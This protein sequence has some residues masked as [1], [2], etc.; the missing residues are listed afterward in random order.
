MFRKI[1]RKIRGQRDVPGETF[2]SFES[3]L[4]AICKHFRPKEVLE[5][6]PG[7][8][9]A[10]ILEHSTAHIVA[11][12]E[13]KKWYRK[14][15]SRFPSERF[16]LSCKGPGWDLR[17]VNSLG[18]PYDLIFVDGGD[19][20]AQLKHCVDLLA[21]D[22]IVVLHDAHREEYEPGIRAYPYFFFPERHSCLMCKSSEVMARLKR[23]L[24]QDLSCHCRYC[25]T[26]ERN[27]YLAK[28]TGED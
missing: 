20:P 23:V 18:G 16:E 5:F 12:E 2:I 17:E 21:S 22:G 24:T 6:G 25:N 27:R 26:E 28:F 11:I 19:R 10:V 15:R 3:H 13:S 8:S 4:A 7:N 14:Y 1:L 9:T